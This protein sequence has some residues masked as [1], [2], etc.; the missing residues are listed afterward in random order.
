MPPLN[1]RDPE[2]LVAPIGIFDSGFGGLTVARSVIDPLRSARDRATVMA[3]LFGDTAAKTLGYPPHG[4]TERAGLALALS[5]ARASALSEG[6]TRPESKG[7][8]MTAKR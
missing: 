2:L 7:T 5:L 6:R 4:L 8:E 1:P 3:C